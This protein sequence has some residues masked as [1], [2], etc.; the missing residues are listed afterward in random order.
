[1]KPNLL[2]IGIGQ[3]VLR[4]RIFEEGGYDEIIKP[5]ILQT[6]PASDTRTSSARPDEELLKYFT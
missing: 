4:T 3:I 2:S 1:M 5:S 6:S